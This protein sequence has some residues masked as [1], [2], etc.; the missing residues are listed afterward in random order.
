MS[1]KD[2]IVTMLSEESMDTNKAREGE[3]SYSRCEQKCWFRPALERRVNCNQSSLI[4]PLLSVNSIKGEVN[5]AT[6]S[7][8]FSGAGNPT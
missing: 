5:G 2:I 6:V 8:D 3:R 1:F 7:V 4:A